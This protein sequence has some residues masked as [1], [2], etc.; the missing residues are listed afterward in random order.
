[1]D[2]ENNSSANRVNWSD[3][4]YD[5][6]RRGLPDDWVHVVSL[7]GSSGYD[8]ADLHAFYSP[9]DRLYFWHGDY[10]C[11]CYGWD[12]GI[13]FEADFNNGD[14]AALRAALKEFAEEHPSAFTLSDA[15][16]VI[17]ALA[18]F[19]PPEVTA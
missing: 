1:M 12:S 16:S 4:G 15:I 2:Y 17:D 10:G 13:S 9:R 3:Y 6:D 18:R 8:W 5:M 11:S 19:N 14:K 7:V